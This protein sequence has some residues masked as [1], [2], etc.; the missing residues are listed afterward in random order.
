MDTTT[1]PTL[2]PWATPDLSLTIPSPGV[3]EG[4]LSYG[5]PLVTLVSSSW[6][7]TCPDCG[8]VE[9]GHKHFDRPVLCVGAD[10]YSTYVADGTDDPKGAPWSHEHVALRLDLEPGRARA[11]WW[12]AQQ[13]KPMRGRGTGANFAYYG[14]VART[15]KR[16]RVSVNGDPTVSPASWRLRL[17]GHGED[18]EIL[19]AEHSNGWPIRY[20]LPVPTLSGLDPDDSRTLPDGS[21]WVDAE[22]LR[23]LVLSA[24]D[25]EV[26]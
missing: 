12:L 17:H 9:K 13:V 16:G 8:R 24:A 15:M 3:L 20:I 22:A 25:M 21:R 2:P 11:A 6:R 10:K 19:F 23:R 5:A 4:L 1:P 14:R 18:H 26:R 7:S